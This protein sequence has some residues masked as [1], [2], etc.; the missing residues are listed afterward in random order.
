MLESVSSDGTKG[1]GSSSGPFITDNGRYIT[2]QSDA[3]NLVAGGTNGRQHIY[4]RDRVAGTTELVSMS[5]AGVQ[6]D[7]LNDI[8]NIS[9]D[10]RFVVFI[11]YASNLVPGDSNGSPD[12]FVR[13]R[14]AG[15]TRRVSVSSSGAQANGSSLWPRISADGRVVAFVSVATNLAGSD[16]N[17]TVEDIYVHDLQTHDAARQRCRAPECKRTASVRSH[18]SVT[19]TATQNDLTRTATLTVNP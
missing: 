8:G 11:S 17:G 6:A 2:F 7:N 5:T 12:V 18:R 16:A 13:D 14:Q 9:G 19:I 10:G 4:V 15:T 3:R 1:I